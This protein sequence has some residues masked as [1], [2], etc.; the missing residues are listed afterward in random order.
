MKPD[1]ILTLI[2][3]SLLCMLREATSKELPV[4]FFINGNIVS[5][6]KF[7]MIVKEKGYLL[8]TANNK[9]LL[10]DTLHTQYGIIMVYNKY[11]T[12]IPILPSNSL[13]LEIYFDNRIFHNLANN[14]SEGDWFKLKYLFRRK[15]L[16]SF[17]N[18]VVAICYQPKSD[19]LKRYDINILPLSRFQVG[20]K[21]WSVGM[22]PWRECMT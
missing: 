22:S 17:G 12:L 2:I 5:G 20:K 1:K 8:Q 11:R 18:G 15:Y 7:Y 14:K 6:A 21:R 4:K 9:I 10:S 3:F 19:Y 13:S 16:V